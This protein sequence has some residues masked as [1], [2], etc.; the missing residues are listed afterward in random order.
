MAVGL[1]DLINREAGYRSL[2]AAHAPA[3]HCTH[4]LTLRLSTVVYA[5][6]MSTQRAQHW[7]PMYWNRLIARWQP[8]NKN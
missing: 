8:N 4:S 3:L 6:S 1:R 5:R 7:L 2:T